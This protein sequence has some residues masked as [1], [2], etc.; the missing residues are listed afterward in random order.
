MPSPRA[1]PSR[2]QRPV[3]RRGLCS[4][5]ETGQSKL[6]LSTLKRKKSVRRRE[7]RFRGSSLHTRPAP[8]P[9]MP[10]PQ[11][12]AFPR[13]E[14]AQAACAPSQTGPR[15]R[16]RRET[17]GAADPLHRCRGRALTSWGPASVA[18]P[19][20]RRSVGPQRPLPPPPQP[21][22]PCPARR[23]GWRLGPRG[24]PAS[25]GPGR[26]G[27]ERREVVGARRGSSGLRATGGQVVTTLPPG[28]VRAPG[29]REA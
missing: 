14:R 17:R 15:A 22:K 20:W 26:G 28:W 10:G 1:P 6:L 11:L 3:A 13:P 12:T 25:A 8:S 27:A 29:R 5:G 7:V 23:R 19:V 9:G 24:I 16:R 18:P 4:G 2:Q 21:P